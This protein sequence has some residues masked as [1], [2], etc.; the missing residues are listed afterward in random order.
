[1]LRIS[2]DSI[3]QFGSFVPGYN[4]TSYHV[5]EAVRTSNLYSTM[6]SANQRSLHPNCSIKKA[7]KEGLY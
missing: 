3:K 5:L 1:M 2:I 4:N 6:I 7:Q